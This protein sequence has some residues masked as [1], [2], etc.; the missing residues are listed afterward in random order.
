MA[1]T[2]HTLPTAACP[3]LRQ[4]RMRSPGWLQPQTQESLGNKARHTLNSHPNSMQEAALPKHTP[5]ALSS[6]H[7]SLR[8]AARHGPGCLPRSQDLPDP[9]E[10]WAPPE[11]A[12]R[13]PAPSTSGFTRGLL[14]AETLGSLTPCRPSVRLVALSRAVNSLHC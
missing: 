12:A 10:G 8:Q 2:T 13:L 14:Q 1:K 7:G 4:L 6:E 11:P 3:V 9:W 5:P